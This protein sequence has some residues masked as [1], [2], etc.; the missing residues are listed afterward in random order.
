ME[1]GTYALVRLDGWTAPGVI[2]QQAAV[3]VH[4]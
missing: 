1:Y 3:A 4:R 2:E